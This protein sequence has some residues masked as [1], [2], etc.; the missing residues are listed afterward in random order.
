[1]FEGTEFDTL[2]LNRWKRKLHRG[3][4]NVF[5]FCNIS[6]MNKYK[7]DSFQCV[8][9]YDFLLMKIRLIKFVD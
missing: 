3:L 8:M 7:C 9:H 2:C 4:A 1:M 6:S 5:A